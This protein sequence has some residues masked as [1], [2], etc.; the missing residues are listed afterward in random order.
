M[1]DLLSKA[2]ADL[3]KNFPDNNTHYNRQWAHRNTGKK[4]A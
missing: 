3:E 2:Q 4:I 1:Y